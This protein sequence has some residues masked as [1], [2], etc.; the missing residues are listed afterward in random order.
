MCRLGKEKQ[1]NPRA[2]QFK[3]MLE[4]VGK[5]NLNSNK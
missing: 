1:K 3:K 2:K 5:N 4:L